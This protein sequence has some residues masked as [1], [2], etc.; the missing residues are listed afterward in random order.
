M[1]LFHAGDAGYVNHINLVISST[2]EVIE[3]YEKKTKPSLNLHTP[4]S[5]L[6]PFK[7]VLV[8]FKLEPRC[9]GFQESVK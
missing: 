5:S 6:V 3:G 7:V 4:T 2:P 8:L 9:A 1:L